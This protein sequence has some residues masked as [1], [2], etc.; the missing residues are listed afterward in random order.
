MIIP[1]GASS[2]FYFGYHGIGQYNYG[3][4]SY[5]QPEFADICTLPDVCKDGPKGFPVCADVNNCTTGRK[6]LPYD[7]KCKGSGSDGCYFD[8][9]RIG[10]KGPH[11]YPYIN[12]AWAYDMNDFIKVKNG[13]MDPWDV[14]PYAVW[15]LPFEV[16]QKT[17]V[18]GGAA[19][20][21]PGKDRIYIAQP[22]S[23]LVGCCEKLPLIHVFQIDRGASE[24]SSYQLEGTVLLLNGDVK[25]KVNDSEE[26]T[27]SSTSRSEP[28]A[29]SFSTK[30]ISGDSYE[31]SV[32]SQPGD[33]SQI[34][35]VYN[36]SGRFTSFYNVS[37][38][39]VY[40]S[41]EPIV[42]DTKPAPSPPILR[43]VDL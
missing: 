33:A 21:D 35:K 42:S 1:K 29:F 28:Q 36:G 10:G 30:F 31:I 43:V 18:F 32:S 6:G 11:A 41:N 25:L 5:N 20:Y 16:A 3:S 9:L 17:S 13:E 15:K 26:I 19:A 7:P 27:V 23:D 12:Q 40:C 38:V 14:L 8:P 22:E 4:P 2:V 24:A 39:V 34:C 37:N